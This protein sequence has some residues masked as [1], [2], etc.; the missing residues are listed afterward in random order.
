M[1]R[2]ITRERSVSWFKDLVRGKRAELGNHWHLK[3]IRE[4]QRTDKTSPCALRHGHWSYSTVEVKTCTICSLSI[5]QSWQQFF[6]RHLS[7]LINLNPPA[8]TLLG[9]LGCQFFVE[10][11]SVSQSY[12]RQEAFQGYFKPV[13]TVIRILP[14]GV[15]DEI[16]ISY[17]KS[18]KKSKGDSGKGSGNIRNGD[19]KKEKYTDNTLTPPTQPSLLVTLSQEGFRKTRKGSED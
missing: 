16:N 19:C 10:I 15:T 18:V 17:Y 13:W 5:K 4:S 12:A 11:P 8:F 9:T 14:Y 6:T 3:C 2:H 1:H 7:S